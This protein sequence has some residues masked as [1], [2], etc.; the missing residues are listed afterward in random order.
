MLLSLQILSGRQ[1]GLVIMHAPLE[2]VAGWEQWG[3][4]LAGRKRLP[5]ASRLRGRH[6]PLSLPASLCVPRRQVALRTAGVI[7]SGQSAGRGEMRMTR[8]EE[9]GWGSV[10]VGRGLVVAQ[11]D[12]PE[13]MER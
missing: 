5:Q 8:G 9:E 6:H 7:A 2:K 1:S 4:Q 10:K 3:E 13:Q 12:C 11:D